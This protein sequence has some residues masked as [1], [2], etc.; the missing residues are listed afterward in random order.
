TRKK[1]IACL[2]NRNN[3]KLKGTNIGVY[4]FL[5]PF[6]HIFGDCNK[7]LKGAKISVTFVRNSSYDNNDL[8]KSASKIGGTG[9]DK[10]EFYSD[11]KLN[12][13]EFIF[14]VAVPKLSVF[15]NALLTDYLIT[16]PQIFLQFNT[17]HLE[18]SPVLQ[19]KQFNW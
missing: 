18:N 17:K 1:K 14:R 13:Q 2:K 16:K 6:S 12:I 7:I 5:L 10:D 11:G 9:A 3:I 19:S 4:T 8:F 15:S